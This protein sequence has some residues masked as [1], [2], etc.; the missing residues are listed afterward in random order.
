M[1]RD[2]DCIEAQFDNRKMTVIGGKGSNI[3]FEAWGFGE[4]GAGGDT[5]VRKALAVN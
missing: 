3:L 1:Q 4:L 5:R 2:A